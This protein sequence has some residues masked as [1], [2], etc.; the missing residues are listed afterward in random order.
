[1]WAMQGALAAVSVASAVSLERTRHVRC[2]AVGWKKEHQR[3]ALRWL[4]STT[5]A[6]LS[7]AHNE[8]CMVLEVYASGCGGRSTAHRLTYTPWQGRRGKF[9]IP[10]PASVWIGAS[11]ALLPLPSRRPP[12]PTNVFFFSYF[13]FSLFLPLSLSTASL[14]LVVSP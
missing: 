9:I 14:C 12:F 4:A 6:R 3:E 8:A 11:R 2:G 10:E 1:M 13:L 7:L 5:S